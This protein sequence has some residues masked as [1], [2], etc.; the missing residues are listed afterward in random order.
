MSSDDVGFYKYHHFKTKIESTGPLD[1]SHEIMKYYKKYRKIGSGAFSNVYF[2]EDI[3]M[4]VKISNDSNI[5]MGSL[6]VEKK[7][8]LFWSYM[9]YAKKINVLSVDDYKG[10][11]EYISNFTTKI[12]GDLHEGNL[13]VVDFNRIPRD[14][15]IGKIIVNKGSQFIDSEIG[16]WDREP[17]NGMINYYTCCVGLKR[18]SKLDDYWGLFNTYIMANKI[19]VKSN[20]ESYEVGLSAVELTI[21]ASLF[22]HNYRTDGAWFSLLV[23]IIFLSD[24]DQTE[25]ASKLFKSS[26]NSQNADKFDILEFYL[27]SPLGLSVLKHMS[28]IGYDFRNTPIPISEYIK[29]LDKSKNARVPW[30]NAV[31]LEFILDELKRHDLDLM[32]FRPGDSDSVDIFMSMVQINESK[33]D[34]VKF[35]IK[36]SY[37]ELLSDNSDD[38]WSGLRSTLQTIIFKD[39][40]VRFIILNTNMG[41]YFEC[42]KLVYMIIFKDREADMYIKDVKMFNV[43]EIKVSFEMIRL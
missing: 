3:Q 34:S 30:T 23:S 9:P 20:S 13:M 43:E 2:V 8:D 4:V 31:R 42:D 21:L 38:R 17:K 5:V 39:V 26:L 27:S 40:R 12:H 6:I 25:V 41:I 28:E 29:S 11:I 24:K 22:F 32:R 15:L 7:D 33:H 37:K 36:D 18:W 19:M 35:V 10:V 14:F 16:G 1:Y